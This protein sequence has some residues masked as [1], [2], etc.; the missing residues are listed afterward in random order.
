[1]TQSMDDQ[2]KELFKNKLRE[3]QIKDQKLKKEQTKDS[4]HK[5][6]YNQNKDYN[7]KQPKNKNYN[8]GKDYQKKNYGVVER[9]QLTEEEK[10]R[11]DKI[12][13]EA[14]VWLEQN[15]A[16]VSD[17]KKIIK[18]TKLKLLVMTFENYSEIQKDMVQML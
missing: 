2:L 17:N 18:E 1:M 11:V 14:G 16:N 4:R 5:K 13:E 8:K 15:K 9:H 10:I 7:K 6:S 12:G 3:I